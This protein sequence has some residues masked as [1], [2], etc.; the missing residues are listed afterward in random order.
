MDIRIIEL[1]FVAL[2]PI[3]CGLIVDYR[4]WQNWLDYVNQD[5]MYGVNDEPS[6]RSLDPANAWL[7]R[8]PSSID[9][10]YLIFESV[11]SDS[12]AAELHDTL[13]EGRDYILLPEEVWHQLYNW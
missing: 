6:P 3:L 11:S 1:Q 10:K 4:W 9:N 13:V 5:G 2:Q 7:S 8:R 12:N